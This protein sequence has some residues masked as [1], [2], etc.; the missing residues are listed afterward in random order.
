MEDGSRKHAERLGTHRGGAQEDRPHEAGDVHGEEGE[1]GQGRHHPR[2]H[3]AEGQRRSRHEQI[4]H[5]QGE[6]FRARAFS[7]ALPPRADAN[8]FSLARSLARGPQNRRNNPDR[9]EIKKYNKYLKKH[10]LHRE[11]KK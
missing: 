9:M 7:P 8:V 5:D 1:A 2:V 10:T 6:F 4:Q 11:I 3:G